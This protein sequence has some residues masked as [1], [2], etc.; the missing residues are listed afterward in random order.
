[1]CKNDTVSH[2]NNFMGISLLVI[3]HKL[4]KTFNNG[5]FMLKSGHILAQKET[6]LKKSSMFAVNGNLMGR[7]YVV[8]LDDNGMDM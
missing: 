2:S 1:M 7:S 5:L 3:R 4:L 8:R 6:P